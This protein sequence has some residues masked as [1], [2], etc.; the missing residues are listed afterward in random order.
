MLITVKTLQQQ[1][2]K[3]EIDPEALVSYNE[4]NCF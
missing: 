3:I 4:R 1:T 2:F